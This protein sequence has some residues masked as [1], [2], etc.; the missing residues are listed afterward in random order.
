[1]TATPESGSKEVR[2]E[3]MAAQWQAG[4][5]DVVAADW[6]EAYFNR[7]ESFPTSKFKDMVDAG[8]GAFAEL[9][10]KNTFNVRNLL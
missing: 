2:A 6:N 4:N 3:P 1:V 7:L 5:F 10:L 9:E 8:S